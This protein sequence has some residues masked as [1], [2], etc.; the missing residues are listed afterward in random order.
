MGNPKRQLIF[1]PCFFR[2]YVK[3]RGC[4]ICIQPYMHTSS[5]VKH[6]FSSLNW[7]SNKYQIP[8]EAW[9]NF[10]LQTY[11]TKHR[12]C[13]R[14]TI[15]WSLVSMFRWCCHRISTERL[16]L[17]DTRL[18]CQV[19]FLSVQK[20]SCFTYFTF[21]ILCRQWDVGVLLL[22]P[23]FLLKYIYIYI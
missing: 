4:I 3:F 12:S 9:I 23:F 22:P 13:D 21:W 19:V 1:Q 7:P 20:N 15:P 10:D 18:I 14:M 11:E 8:I 16:L 17:D 6:F 2:G 5:S